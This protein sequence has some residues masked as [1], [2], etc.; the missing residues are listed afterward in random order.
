MHPVLD[1]SVIVPFADDEDLIGSAVRRL[2]AH[3]RENTLSFEIIAVDEDS[4]DNSHA[5]LALLRPE[6][7]ELRISN[8]PGRSRGPAV[9]AHRARGRVLWM[10]SPRAAA[11]PLA[12]FGRAYRRVQRHEVDLVSVDGR[13]TVCHR[14]RVLPLIDSLRGNTLAFQRRL[15]RRAAARGLTVDTQVLGR[16]PAP[17]FSAPAAL[18]RPIARLFAVLGTR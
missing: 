5:V 15:A 17:R 7:P 16:A 12:P 14:V 10:I 11:T 1:V 9:G 8:A 2:A 18:Q 4:G 3:L 13:F 6:V